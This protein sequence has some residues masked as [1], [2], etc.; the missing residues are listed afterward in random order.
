V[1]TFQ[2]HTIYGLNAGAHTYNPSYSGGIDQEDHSSRIV[3]AKFSEIEPGMVIHAS[4]SSYAG[5]QVGE[6]WSEAS[7]K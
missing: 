2:E 4:S 1:S 7:P 6:S 3:R 5:T